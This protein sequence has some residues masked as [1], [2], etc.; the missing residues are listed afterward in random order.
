MKYLYLLAD[1]TNIHAYPTVLC[2]SVF[3]L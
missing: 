3:R 1:R 2:L